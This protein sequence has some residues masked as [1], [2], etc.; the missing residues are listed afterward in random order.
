MIELRV[1]IGS[2]MSGR[3]VAFILLQYHLLTPAW[4]RFMTKKV[5]NFTS[6]L[7]SLSSQL[8]EFY[9]EFGQGILGGV[10]GYSGGT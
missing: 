3:L 9:K 7:R 2:G 8:R 1:L 6:T 4:R 5:N 10:R